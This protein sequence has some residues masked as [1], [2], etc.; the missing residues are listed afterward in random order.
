MIKLKYS[1]DGKEVPLNKLG[2]ALEQGIYTRAIE[3]VR[4]KV[5]QVRCPVHKVGLTSLT[6]KKAEGGVL[7]FEMEACCEE[8]TEACKEAIQQQ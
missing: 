8:L 6:L 1:V 2:S 7:N 4:R 3:G 5:D